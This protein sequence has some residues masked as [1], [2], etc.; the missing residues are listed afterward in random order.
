[1]RR[2]NR[3]GVATEHFVADFYFPTVFTTCCA[4]ARIGPPATGFFA[5]ESTRK[6]KPSSERAQH[7]GEEP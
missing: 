3:L 6:F 7:Q 4:A 1:M 5:R 2:G